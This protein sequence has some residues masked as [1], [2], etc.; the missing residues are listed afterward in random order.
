MNTLTEDSSC[1]D[2]MEYE[3]SQEAHVDVNNTWKTLHTDR[4]I[5]L[6][7]MPKKK[8]KLDNDNHLIW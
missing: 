6:S 8:I 4:H 5:V 2:P 7:K 3:L 1:K